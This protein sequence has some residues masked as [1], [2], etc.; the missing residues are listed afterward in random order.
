VELIGVN[1]TSVSATVIPPDFD[2]TQEISDWSVLQFPEF[3][4]AII[5]SEDNRHEYAATYANFTIPGDYTVIVDAENPDGSADPV[6]T[7]ITA[8]GTAITKGDVNNDG[9]VRSNDA[10]LAMRIAAGLITATEYQRQAADIN[11][12]GRVR[13]NDAILILRKAAGLDTP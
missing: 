1:V 11:G 8:T 6:Q 10:I 9:K 4:L 2:P 13:S 12:D 5:S 3:D 7:T